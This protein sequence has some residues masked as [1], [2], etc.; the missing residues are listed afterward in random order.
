MDNFV[1]TFDD[2]F[3]SKITSGNSSCD[4]CIRPAKKFVIG[5]SM[6][7]IKVCR[8]NRGYY[9]CDDSCNEWTLSDGICILHSRLHKYP[10]GYAR[11]IQDYVNDT[12][13]D[14]VHASFIRKEITKEQNFSFREIIDF[15]LYIPPEEKYYQKLVE[16]IKIIYKSALSRAVFTYWMSKQVFEKHGICELYP[17]ELV[18]N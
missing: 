16:N 15:T 3:S 1:I 2:Y 12:L 14:R 7:S 11:I 9:C 18:W 10:Q 8:F 17:K 4:Y 5:V 6:K 13:K